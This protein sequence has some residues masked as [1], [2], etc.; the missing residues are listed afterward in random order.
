MY[1]QSV[2]E[3]GEILKEL[4]DSDITIDSVANILDYFYQVIDC[5]VSINYFKYLFESS[6]Y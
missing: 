5:T 1:T 3:I 6:P 4:S 2:K